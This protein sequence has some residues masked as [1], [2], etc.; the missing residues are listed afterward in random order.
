MRPYSYILYS[1]PYTGKYLEPGTQTRGSLP[2][3]TRVPLSISL[4]L[5][6]QEAL[7]GE[8]VQVEEAAVGLF[9]NGRAAEWTELDL[10]GAVTPRPGLEESWTRWDWEEE[11]S[12][13]GPA[14]ENG[15]E[16]TLA[17]YARD[18]YGRVVTL[19]L[20]QGVISDGEM[21]RGKLGETAWWE[22][23]PYQPAE[24]GP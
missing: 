9:V 15:D 18:N 16:L 12:L 3:G 2:Q 24:V 20:W 10:S 23:W 4:E 21:D 6:S 8:A 7:A 1:E 22:D 19:L 5:G 11:F 13:D 17:L 14:L